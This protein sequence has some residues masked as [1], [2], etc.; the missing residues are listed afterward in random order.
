MLLER[1][2]LT[3]AYAPYPSNLKMLGYLGIIVSSALIQYL[4]IDKLDNSLFRYKLINNNEILGDEVSVM[5]EKRINH[6]AEQ[7]VPAFG[8]SELPALI[9]ILLDNE[10][11]SAKFLVKS[12]LNRIMTP[13][14]KA[15]D[16][17]GLVKDEC[18]KYDLN[19]Y[20]HWLNDHCIN[21]YYKNISKFGTYTEGVW[22]AVKKYTVSLR[23]IDSQKNRQKEIDEISQERLDVDFIDMG[24]YLSRREARLN[25]AAPVRIVLKNEQEVLAVLLDISSSGIRIKVPHCIEVQ[26]KTDVKVFFCKSD[27]SYEDEFTRA[28]HYHIVAIDDPIEH[29]PIK[30]LRCVI[31]KNKEFVDEIMSY[32]ERQSRKSL[33]KHEIPNRANAHT[34]EHFLFANTNKIPFFFS[35]E[36]ILLTLLN[37]KNKRLYQ[38]LKNKSGQPCLEL[39]FGKSMLEKLTKLPHPGASL[40]IHTFKYNSEFLSVNN[41]EVNDDLFR[42]FVRTGAQ[43]D[44][45]KIFKVSVFKLTQDE[46]KNLYKEAPKLGL[47]SATHYGLLQEI[48]YS[49]CN[50]DYL[51]RQPSNLSIS[52]LGRF[53]AKSQSP[54]NVSPY[55]IIGNKLPNSLLDLL[56]DFFVKSYSGVCVFFGK[57][58][59]KLFPRSIG[60]TYPSPQFVEIFAQV[61][62]SKLSLSP[63]YKGRSFSLIKQTLRPKEKH[64]LYSH[65]LYVS[66]TQYKQKIKFSESRLENEFLDRNEKIDFIKKSQL[67][68]YFFALRIDS[69]RIASSEIELL[70]FDVADVLR[71]NMQKA[72]KLEYDIENIAGL[73]EITDVTDE[74]LLRLD[75][76][77]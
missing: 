39:L 37:E 45:W 50:Q 22:E 60:A 30:Y 77:L 69:E 10:P 28:A 20:S 12:E 21:L 1:K 68:G 15:I 59:T 32:Y 8:T 53:R 43:T 56:H 76:K 26:V 64:G 65:E 29:S 47:K 25:I 40:V 2:T 42:L 19:G 49:D 74:V 70:K 58:G 14:S 41:D 48:T 71:V 34:H 13:C 55:I 54:G 24:F 3:R 5:D 57:E 7:L 16:V 62:G 75:L 61:N 11:A 36:Q 31:E 35:K 72:K 18:R 63:I 23:D 27:N 46:I 67:T 44:T 33:N 38:S 17:R 66:V 4:K 9:D 73:A 52:E 51:L 6:L